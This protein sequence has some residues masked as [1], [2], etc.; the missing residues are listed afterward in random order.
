LA[1]FDEGP[2]TSGL[3]VLGRS[4]RI[5]TGRFGWLKAKQSEKSR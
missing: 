3:F 2:L 5:Q 1:E 4:L